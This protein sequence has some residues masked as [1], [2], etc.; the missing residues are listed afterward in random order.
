MDKYYL[1]KALGKFRKFTLVGFCRYIRLKLQGK[2]VRVEGGCR[3]CGSCCQQISLEVAGRWIQSPK[4]FAQVVERHPE[5][6][7]F[8]IIG[9]DQQGYL[10]FI[11]DWFDLERG[12]RDYENRLSICRD[13]P[14]ASLYIAGGDVPPGCGYRFVTA[15]PFSTIL[16]KKI[17]QHRHDSPSDPHR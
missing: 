12:C 14:L 6:S 10:L 2:H 7:R 16:R 15:V 13:F 11:C 4:Q 5:Y 1:Y 8:T 17:E 3:M 9:M